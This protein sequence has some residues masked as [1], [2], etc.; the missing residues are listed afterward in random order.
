MKK[1]IFT[2]FVIFI[3]TLKTQAQLDKGTWLVGGN[4]SFA[5]SKGSFSTDTYSQ[6]SKETNLNISP[7][8]GYFLLDKLAVG[9]KPGFTWYKSL[10]TTSG[11][12]SN[13]TRFEVGPFVRY[14]FLDKTKPVN[15]LSEIS[16]QHEFITAKPETGSSNTF[17]FNAG[18]VIYFNSSVGLEFTV[19][20]YSHSEN[21]LSYSK[22]TQKSFKMGIGF[23]IHLQK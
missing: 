7:N 1:T 11:A 12:T 21:F 20:Y 22:T 17:S 4:G 14:Y 8:I 10:I 2:V 13:S 23:Q 18:P 3:V 6:E 15:I 5:S 19:G 16:Y 9:I